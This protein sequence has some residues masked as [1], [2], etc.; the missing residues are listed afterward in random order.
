MVHDKEVMGSNPDTKYWMDVSVDASYYIK[1]KLRIK[2]AKWNK[3]KK[4]IIRIK[5]HILA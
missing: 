2:V 3:P 5:I 1:R 4:K